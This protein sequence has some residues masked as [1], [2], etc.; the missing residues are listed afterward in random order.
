MATSNMP[1][2][3]GGTDYLSQYAANLATYQSIS[4]KVNAYMSANGIGTST[5]PPAKLTSTGLGGF[6]PWYVWAGV[7]VAVVGGLLY[8]SES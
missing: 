1:G 7:A 2:I 8:L 3:D 4:D 6:V 5:K